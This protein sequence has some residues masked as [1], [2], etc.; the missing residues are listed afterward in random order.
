MRDPYL[1]RFLGHSTLTALLQVERPLPE[2]TKSQFLRLLPKFLV[3]DSVTVDLEVRKA[4]SDL[5]EHNP[6]PTVH[7]GVRCDG[8]GQFPLVGIRYKCT[9]CSDFDLC[10]ACESQ[11]IHPATHALIKSKQPIP[12]M[13]PRPQVLPTSVSSSA[14][15]V[16]GAFGGWRSRCPSNQPPAPSSV[17]ETVAASVPAQQAQQSQSSPSVSQWAL[18]I[19]NRRSSAQS[20]SQ[21]G[22]ASP[23]S[24]RS[25]E[26]SQAQIGVQS[27]A[28][29]MAEFV[30]VFHI[31]LSI[32]L[33]IFN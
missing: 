22:S 8:C 6:V 31:Y 14:A 24:W 12:T 15:Y 23:R 3:P 26:E 19:W 20:Q 10:Q 4:M 33:F 32:Y 11:G 21:L 30:E 7:D 13:P 18:P 16:P 27:E 1:Q 9:E 17:K 5:L 29:P 2:L 25:A 28:L